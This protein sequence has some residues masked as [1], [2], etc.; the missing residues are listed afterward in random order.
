VRILNRLIYVYVYSIYRDPSD[1]DWVRSTS[2]DWIDKITAAN[3]EQQSRIPA[4][5]STGLSSF[6]WSRVIEKGAA[7]AI[8]GGILGLLVAVMHGLQKFFGRGKNH[9]A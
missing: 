5:G 7:G 2:S 9:D 4:S 8:V 6:D 1:L 3:F